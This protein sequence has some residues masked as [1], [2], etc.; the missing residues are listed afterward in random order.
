MH[1]S[2]ESLDN[3]LHLSSDGKRLIRP[4]AIFNLLIIVTLPNHDGSPANK[5]TYSISFNVSNQMKCLSTP[6]N[7]N[8][9]IYNYLVD[10]VSILTR[11]MPNTT[12][13]YHEMSFF[14]AISKHNNPHPLA[15]I[16]SLDQI[17]SMT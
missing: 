15:L 3:S 4:Y 16:S 13:N 11:K 2:T 1:H 6:Y 9:I 5:L 10:Q 12:S 8:K 7:D 17:Y 14:W